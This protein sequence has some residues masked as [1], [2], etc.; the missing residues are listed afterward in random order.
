MRRCLAPVLALIAMTLLSS[1]NT[2]SYRDQEN[3]DSGSKQLKLYKVEIDRRAVRGGARLLFSEPPPGD[4]FGF[5]RLAGGQFAI[6]DSGQL[7]C[8]VAVIEKSVGVGGRPIQQGYSV[9]D[10]RGR[11]ADSGDVATIFD[12][13]RVRRT[14]LSGVVD[15]VRFQTMGSDRL[16]V[17]GFSQ[18]KPQAYRFFFTRK[19]IGARADVAFPWR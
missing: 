4:E 11:V 9:L 19:R 5:S 3:P 8:Q 17:Q 18:G 6:S 12:G 1:C 2:P 7:V 14:D 10:F 15:E 16:V 13:D